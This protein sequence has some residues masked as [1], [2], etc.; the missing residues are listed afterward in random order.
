[1]DVKKNRQ[2]DSVYLLIRWPSSGSLFDTSLVFPTAFEKGRVFYSPRGHIE[3]D[4]T[5]EKGTFSC[6]LKHSITAKFI[7]VH[8]KL[9]IKL[10][11]YHLTIK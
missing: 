6:N 4:R 2:G 3:R 10:A 7:L 1:M 8:V 5:Y 9:L 11:C